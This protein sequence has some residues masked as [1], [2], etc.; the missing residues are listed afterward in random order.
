MNLLDA[1]LKQLRDPQKI[2]HSV[3]ESFDGIEW[4]EKRISRRRE[5]Q[6]ELGQ[7]ESATSAE[8]HWQHEAFYRAVDSIIAE[9]NEH[10]SNSWH[11]LEA[12][13]IFSPKVFSTFS[14][15]YPT[16]GHV[17]ENVR[18]FHETYKIDSHHCAVKLYILAITFKLFNFD[19]VEN[20]T[21]HVDYS[22]V[23]D[24]FSD[25]TED[26]DDKYGVDIQDKHQTFVD[27]LSVLTDSRYKLIDAY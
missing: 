24:E 6:G 20:K 8:E 4:E 10:F 26:M 18:K 9:I 14:E 21:D 19:T 16:T 11:I 12:L 13:A 27:C 23:S 1:A 17:E 25:S 22:D 3:E 7:D 15:F 2:T 5:V